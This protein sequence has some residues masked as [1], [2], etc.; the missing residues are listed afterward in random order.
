MTR[1]PHLSVQLVAPASRPRLVRL[2]LTLGSIVALPAVWEERKHRRL[3]LEDL[4]LRAPHLIDD[5]GMTR[6][7]V[8]AEIAKPFWRA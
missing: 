8:E 3:Q 7:Q 1:F 2:P 5:M 6:R 4:L